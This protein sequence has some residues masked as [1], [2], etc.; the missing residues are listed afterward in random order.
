M[1]A[2]RGGSALSHAL[3]LGVRRLVHIRVLPERDPSISTL[4]LRSF[5]RVFNSKNLQRT[6]GRAHTGRKRAVRGGDKDR[7]E[8]GTNKLARRNYFAKWDGS[9]SGNNREITAPEI[10]AQPRM[11]PTGTVTSPGEGVGGG[12][13][14]NGDVVD[15]GDGGGSGVSSGDGGSGSSN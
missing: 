9:L 7:G 8:K 4:N 12:V 14:V 11:C 5:R 15:V 13:D 10:I 6:G 2:T 1:L 3:I